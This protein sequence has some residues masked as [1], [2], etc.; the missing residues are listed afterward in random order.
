MN[1]TVLRRAFGLLGP[2]EATLSMVAFLVSLRAVGWL[3]GQ[4]FPVGRDLMAASGAAFM[5]VVIAQ[6][7]NAFACRSSTRWPGDLGWTTNRLL[8][9]AASAGL[10][11]SLVVLLVT[12]VALALGH[13]SPPAAGWVVA[14]SSAPIVLAVDALDKRIRAGRP[15][16]DHQR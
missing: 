10:A 14:L 5:T 13:A 7:A 15:R 11:F 3:P 2:V 6:T 4:A 1:R 8:L 9:P 12:P 16:P